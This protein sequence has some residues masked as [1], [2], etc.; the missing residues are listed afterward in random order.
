VIDVIVAPD[1]LRDEIAARFAAIV[2]RPHDPLP[3][4]RRSITP[5]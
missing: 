5:M 4:K 3:P 2:E 1:R